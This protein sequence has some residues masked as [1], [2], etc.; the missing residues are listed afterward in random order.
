MKAED[1]IES[2]REHTAVHEAGHAVL[3]LVTGIGVRSVTIV[4]NFT[5]M[6]AGH[7]LHGGEW[8]DEGSDAEQL[9]LFAEDA[10]WLRHAI[11][12]YAGAEAVRK[13]RP[14][15]SADE[16][17]EDDLRWAANALERV[18]SDDESLD[19]YARLAKRRCTL[20]VEHYCPEI[21]RVA[22][23]LLERDTL[24]EDDVRAIVSESTLTRQA[25][26][27]SW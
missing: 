16:G 7:A 18:T 1:H 20:L 8:P 19:L 10:F 5:E 9:R 27:L 6:T 15:D 4:P 21:E 26:L 23:A 22:A 17:A 2:E 3:Q 12:R 25:G 11:S 13:I 14:G 24:D